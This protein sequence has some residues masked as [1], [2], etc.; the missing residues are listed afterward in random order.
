LKKI[1]RNIVILVNLAAVVGLVGAMLSVYIPPDKFWPPAFLGLLYPYFLALNVLFVIYWFIF[2]WKYAL[3]SLSV[4]LIGFGA[5]TRFYQWK[6][7]TAEQTDIKVLSYNVRH[8]M[9][10]FGTNEDRKEN[11][12]KIIRFLQESDADIICLQES[13]LRRNDVFNLS[14]TVKELDNVQHYQFASSSSTF[15]SVTMTRFPIVNMGE[16]RFEHSRN[17]S[18]F[19]DMLID[20]DTVRVYNL[21]LQSYRIDPRNYAIL[22]SGD[23]QAEKNRKVY[24]KVAGQ[25]KFAF[26]KRAAQAREISEHIAG[27]PYPVIVCGD[28][29][30]TSTSYAYHT[31]KDELV[32]AFVRSGSGIGQTYVGQLPSFRIDFILHS[33]TLKSYNFE[34][35]NFKHSDHLPIVCD[36]ELEK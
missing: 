1:F 21:H 23:I 2:R 4:I 34:T 32:D 36:F 9:G 7:Q 17:I 8:F 3:V 6:G 10:D 15:G 16:L 30:D 26:A 14:K 12:D 24:R 22:E 29:N 20:G 18:I 13:R 25:M 5:F 19:T 35:L 28:F 11:S 31:I 27:C 33:K